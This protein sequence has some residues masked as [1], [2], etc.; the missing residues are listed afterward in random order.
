MNVKVRR[1]LLFV[2][3][4]R[5]DRF[6]KAV[7][8]G[9]DMVCI[10]LED[11]VIPEEK[12]KARGD[13]VQYLQSAA[14][15]SELVVRVNRVE[16]IFGSD[17]LQALAVAAVQP[18]LIILPKV[19]TAE[20]VVKAASYFKEKPV[21]LVALIES[22]KGLLNLQ[23]IALAHESLEAL[24]FGGAD[25][26]AELRGEM[27]WEPLFYARGQLAVVAAA[28]GLDLIDVPYLD[29]NDDRGLREETLRIKAMGFTAKSAIH[30][31]QVGA[32]NDSYTPTVEQVHK[33]LR[34][35]RA[36]DESRGGVVAVDG[37]MVDK[38]VVKSAERIMAIAGAM[39]LIEEN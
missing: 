9:A 17:D 13:V 26:A 32:I 8:A 18:D 29:I 36:N 39:G 3:G 38:P 20:E 7:A 30:P 15:S 35:V 16:D 28:A 6:E 19:E 12:T 1:S 2:P 24:M 27:R 34:I 31:R 23:E 37:K 10:D 5:P 22:P 14:Q 25:F 4:S 11:A 21:A 33:A